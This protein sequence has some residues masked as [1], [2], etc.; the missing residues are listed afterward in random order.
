MCPHL[1]NCEEGPSNSLENGRCPCTATD[2]T[3]ER[4][5][6]RSEILADLAGQRLPGNVRIW[7]H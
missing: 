3:I 4:A 7:K 1:V 6:L 2:E 5:G